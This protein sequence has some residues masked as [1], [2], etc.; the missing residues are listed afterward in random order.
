MSN[1]M[2]SGVQPFRHGMV[3]GKCSGNG[4]GSLSKRRQNAT[5]VCR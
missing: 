3:G 5:Q 2:Q 4:K 1:G